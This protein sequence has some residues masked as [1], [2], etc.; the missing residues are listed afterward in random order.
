MTDLEDDNTTLCN[1][2]TYYQNISSLKNIAMKNEKVLINDR[3]RV[4]R[5]SYLF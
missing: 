4:S 2:L 1:L 5:R 3:L